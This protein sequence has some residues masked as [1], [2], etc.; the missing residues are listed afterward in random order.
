MPTRFLALTLWAACVLAGPAHAA[1][2]AEWDLTGQPGD[3]AASTAS[4]SAAGI[5]A[6]DLSRGAGLTPNIG[7]NSINAAGWTGQDTDYFT[8]GFTVDAGSDVDLDA[9]FVGARSSN[10]GPGMVGLFYSGDGFASSLATINLAPGTNFVNTEIDLT[11]LPDLTGTVEFRFYAIGTTGANQSPMTAGGT[12]RLTDYF[13][14][15]AEARNL[16]FTGTIAAVP[17]PATCLM[18]LAGMALLSV[19]ISRRRS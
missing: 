16:Q 14:G 10:T 18:S 6:L 12:F 3:Q 2:I 4:T 5:T 13:A 7:S 15:G 19:A 11:A 9:L 17:E 8:L 1:I